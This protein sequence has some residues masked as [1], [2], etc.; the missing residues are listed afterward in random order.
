MKDYVYV[1]LI[2]YRQSEQGQA[3]LLQSYRNC[4]ALFRNID[5]DQLFSSQK[6]DHQFAHRGLYYG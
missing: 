3:L 1:T 6:V 5:S 4:L 2:A